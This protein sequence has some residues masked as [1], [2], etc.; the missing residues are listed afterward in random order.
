MK[1]S[2]LVESTISAGREDVVSRKWYRE[3]YFIEGWEE[4]S[5]SFNLVLAYWL[6]SVKLPTPISTSIVQAEPEPPLV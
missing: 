4:Y 3:G 5:S 2:R 6:A 1:T